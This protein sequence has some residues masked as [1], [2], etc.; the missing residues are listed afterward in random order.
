MS[1]IVERFCTQSANVSGDVWQWFNS[2][3]REEWVV[4]LGVTSVLGFLCM[5]GYG[6][7]SKY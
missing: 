3:T 1:G 2:L 6:S 7:R 4:V 5:L